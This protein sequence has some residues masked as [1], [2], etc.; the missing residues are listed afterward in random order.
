MHQGMST[1]PSDAALVAAL[2]TRSIVLVGM[3]GAGKSSIGRRLAARLGIPFV[4]ADH[5]IEAAARMTIQDIFAAYG[6]ASF[7]SGEMRVIARLLEAGPQVVATGGGAFIHPETRSTIRRSGVSIWLKADLDVLLRRVK[8]RNDRPLLKT[9]D[10]SETLTKLLT[11]REPIYAQADATVHSR[12]VPHEMILEEILA[13]LAA[14]LGFGD[15]ARAPAPD[16][17]PA[18]TAPMRSPQ[19]DVVH[20]PLG[21]RGYDVVIGRGILP[22]LG[23]RM[24]SLK[25]GASAAVVTDSTVATHHLGAAQAALE[26]AGI[27]PVPIVVPP[28]EGSKSWST[29]EKICEDLLSARIERGDVVVA[30]GGGVIGDL[31]GFAAAIVRRGLDV[32]QVPTTLLAQVDSALGGKTAVNSRHGKNQVG[33]FHQPILVVADTASLDTLPQRVF[34]AGYAEIVKYGLIG[35]ATFFAW[36]EVNWREVFAGA[37]ARE[38]AIATSCRAKAA[39]VGR[40]ERE[41]GERALLNLGHTFAHALEAAAGYSDR[42][43]H[44]E[45][46]AIGLALAFA[47]SAR[48]GLLPEAEAERV[49]SHLAAVGLPTDMSAIPG[50]LP[51][52]D[53][54]LE[55]MA[56]D[57]KVR[58]GKLTLILARGIGASFVAPDIDPALVRAFVAEKLAQP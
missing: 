55:L 22:G 42:L 30:L 31:A 11:E 49:R 19:P 17:G 2:G 5:E 12:E 13:A 26:R 1:L 24:A 15:G 6:E 18:M 35:D 57:K 43:L 9:G 44:G 58:R 46:V 20:V 7:R 50:G 53:G 37:P 40:D 56:Q 39:I 28:G 51:A 48:L 54:L 8:R 21:P 36:L 4:D 25:P 10:P 32:V 34:R 16:R 14:R 3:M 52:A 29:L 47:F 33:V 41:S 27:R 23:E 38:H 45:A